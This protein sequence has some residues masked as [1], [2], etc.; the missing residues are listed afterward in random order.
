MPRGQATTPVPSSPLARNIKLGRLL[1]GMTQAELA[2]A[3]G[4]RE[5]QTVSNWERGIFK[6]SDENLIA[7][8][9]TLGRDL[10]WFYTDHSQPTKE[11]A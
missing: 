4:I 9:Q 8:C 6:P 3:A 10:P 7:L 5:A 2:Q 1:A 11:A